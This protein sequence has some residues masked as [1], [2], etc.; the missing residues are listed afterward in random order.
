MHNNFLYIGNYS[1]IFISKNKH[2]IQ[3]PTNPR[4][5]HEGVVRGEVGHILHLAKVE[6]KREHFLLDL[7]LSKNTHFKIHLKN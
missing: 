6:L 7:I 5:Q 4:P 3:S 2:N 1:F